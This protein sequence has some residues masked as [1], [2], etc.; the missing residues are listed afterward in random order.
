MPPNPPRDATFADVIPPPGPPPV[1]RAGS[2][3]AP[4]TTPPDAD[5][6]LPL[7]E[8]PAIEKMQLPLFTPS[9]PA[10]DAFVPPAPGAPT[11]A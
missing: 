10:P 7:A 11:W 9:P 3:K 8:A 1:G 6:E 4:S 2:E 5:A